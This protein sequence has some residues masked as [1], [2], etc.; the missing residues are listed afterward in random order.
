MQRYWDSLIYVVEIKNLIKY[1]S[2]LS[3]CLISIVL[4][5]TLDWLWTCDDIIDNLTLATLKMKI[6]K[7]KKATSK[8][9]FSLEWSNKWTVNLFFFLNKNIYVAFTFYGQI[10]NICFFLNKPMFFPCLTKSLPKEAFSW[11]I[12]NLYFMTLLAKK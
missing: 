6:S 3:I 5:A 7:E 2:N 12:A 8:I 10:R 9:A 1:E 11:L 4:I